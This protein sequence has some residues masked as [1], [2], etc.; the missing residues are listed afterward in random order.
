MTETLTR[1]FIGEQDFSSYDGSDN[2]TF[3]RATSTGGTITLNKVGREVDVYVCYGQGL[4]VYQRGMIANA[5]AAIGANKET[6]VLRPETWAIDGD[7]TIPSNVSL[8]IPKGAILE[9]A[10]GKTLTINGPIECGLYQVFSCVGT[11]KVVFGSTSIDELCVEWWGAVGDETTDDTA[12]IKAALVAGVGRTI[13]FQGKGYLVTDAMTTIATSGTVI[14]GINKRTSRIIFRPS[15]DDKTLFTFSAGAAILY[16]CGVKDITLTPALAYTATSRTAGKKT[17]ILISD[18]SEFDI[19]NVVIQ[20]WS[21]TAQD[22]VGLHIKGREYINLNN[23]GIQA[24]RPIVFDT[25]PNYLHAL[26]ASTWTGVYT[27]GAYDYAGAAYS[28]HPCIEAI[29]SAQVQ[30]WTVNG[31]LMSGISGGLYLT[32]TFAGV[33][34]SIVIDGIRYEQPTAATGST[35]AIKIA[36]VTQPLYGLHINGFTGGSGAQHN[37]IYIRNTIGATI[38]DSFYDGTLVDLDIDNTTNYVNV[39]NLISGQAAV[40]RNL[41]TMVQSGPAYTLPYVVPPV[42]LYTIAESASYYVAVKTRDV[43]AASGSESFTGFGFSPKMVMITGYLGTDTFLFSQGSASNT[44]P[45][46]SN[47]QCIAFD[48]AGIPTEVAAVVHF[49]PALGGA[50]RYTGIVTAFGADGITIAWTKTGTPT[51]TAVYTITAFR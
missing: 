23:V 31:L 50:D 33:A 28:P 27:Y 49:D 36:P 48:G 15:V 14:R 1:G 37:G 18:V 19:D 13:W 10:T 43:S 2:R 47:Q 34:K 8:K 41:G 6:I 35:Y 32:S 38:E 24:D 17:A 51:G 30:R 11:G 40:T 9:I 4:P 20:F 16:R 5:L 3:T 12:A 44:A 26:D 45:I 39:R 46:A 42:A 29:N 7:L 22:S 21:G 25:N